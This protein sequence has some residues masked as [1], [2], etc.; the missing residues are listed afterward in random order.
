M[1][2]E[3]ESRKNT[4]VRDAQGEVSKETI[5]TPVEKTKSTQRK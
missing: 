4:S 3:R 2:K 1:N 5:L